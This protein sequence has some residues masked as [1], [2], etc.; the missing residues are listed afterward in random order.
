MSHDHHSQAD[1]IRASTSHNGHVDHNGMI[2]DFR[3]RFV[4]S[5][6][7]TLP[8]VALSP[9]LQMW[10]G[11]RDDLHFPGDAH[12]LFV[13]S[14]IIFVYGGHPFLRGLYHDL[15]QRTP[16][17]MT[18][19][20]VAISISYIYSSATVFGLPGEGF[21]W[22][23]ATLI[24]L[25]LLGHWIEMRSIL[26]ASRALESLATL[27]PSV[28]HVMRP[29]GSIEDRPIDQLRIGDR[30]LV[31]PGERVPADGSV[32]DGSTTVDESMLTGEST[33]ISKQVGDQV[34]GGS[35]NGEGSMT[36]AVEKS[37]DESFLAQVIDLVRQAQES[38]S[39][40][41]DLADRAARWLTLTA[42][43]GGA[44]TFIAWFSLSGADLAFALERAVT[45]MVISCPHALGL[46]IPLVVAVST[47]IAA[48]SG[49][50]IRNRMAFE[51][52]RRVGMVIFDKTGTL[53]Q[54]EF[55]VTDVVTGDDLSRDDLLRLAAS[56]ESHSAHPIATAISNT[57]DDRLHV[58]NFHSITG[59]GAEGVVDG[60]RITVASPG[61]VRSTG[62]VLDD[63]VIDRL[64]NQGKT[65]V[66]VLRDGRSVGTLALADIVRPE[67]AQAVARLHEMGIK[68]MMLTGDNAR[69]A[70]H[71]ADQIGL[72]EY[73]AEVLPEEKGAT[74]RNVQSS[75]LVVAMAGDGVN[76]APALAQA[77]VGIAVGAGTDVAIETAD[78][79]L[80]RSNPLDIV[81]TIDLS[82]RTYSKMKQNL[83]W[84]A[85]YNIVA[86][87]LAAGI[88]SA[89]DIVLSPAVGAVL[90]SL[91]TIVV[92]INARM[93]KSQEVV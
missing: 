37:G 22:E 24:D 42:I 78:V 23:L 75:G 52:A 76:D 79:V 65:V 30:L 17:M 77:D 19:V 83:W 54:G 89:Y 70:R 29:D 64:E 18:L 93:M 26:G 58:S 57:V 12:V 21:F 73:V 63:D 61:Y 92:A 13:L 39:R 60:S 81:T 47:S 74:V 66:S 45:V 11:L 31:R 53:T 36:V 85:G 55:G 10:V 1:S 6:L 67:S 43:S 14:T 41:Q 44:I 49:L 28:A 7:L 88:L 50:L 71:V 32:R 15:R 86:I 2:D 38:K 62:A 25:M 8:V 3:R 34:I 72:D 90:M 4:I 59:K 48:G 51:Q 84:A 16:G 35:I 46:A 80:V 87:P 33:P 27:M 91:S 56:V 82:R 40:A 68:A 5:L 20:G 69:A 9:M